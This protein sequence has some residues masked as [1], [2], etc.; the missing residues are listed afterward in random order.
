MQSVIANRFF[1]D[2]GELGPFETI[3]GNVVIDVP[4]D[5]ITRVTLALACFF[6]FVNTQSVIANRLAVSMK[7]RGSVCCSIGFLE[8][9]GSST[10]LWSAPC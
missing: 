5:R 6:D 4:S 10:T 9:S 7:A 8:T 2:A 1:G 3:S